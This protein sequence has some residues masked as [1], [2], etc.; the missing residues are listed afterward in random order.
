MKNSKRRIE[1]ILC[2]GNTKEVALKN[3]LMHDSLEDNLQWNLFRIYT[4]NDPLFR[5]CPLLGGFSEKVE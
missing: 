3:S 2:L 1:G 5:G 4:E